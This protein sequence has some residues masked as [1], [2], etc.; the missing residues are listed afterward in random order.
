MQ[1]QYLH[2]CAS[3]ASKLSTC[4]VDV[5][6][7]GNLPADRLECAAHFGERDV[8]AVGGRRYYDHGASV[9]LI[10][11]PVLVLCVCVCVLLVY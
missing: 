5:V 10:H 4:D 1:R 9:R 3:K 8:V 6:E 11:V 7:R 2:F